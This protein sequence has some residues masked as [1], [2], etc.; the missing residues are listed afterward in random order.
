MKLLRSSSLVTLAKGH[1]SCLSTFSK[2]LSSETTRPISFKFHVQPSNKGGKKVYIFCPGHLT[3]IA[4]MSIYGKNLKKTFS[5]PDCR[6]TWYV[7]YLALLTII[8]CIAN[9]HFGTVTLS[10]QKISM[11]VFKTNITL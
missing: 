10:L 1:I 11:L 4:T 2:G 7:V 9:Y 3:K 5:S 8:S 6:E